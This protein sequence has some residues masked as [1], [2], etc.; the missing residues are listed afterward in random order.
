MLPAHAAPERASERMLCL[1]PLAANES[2]LGSA[3]DPSPPA[4]EPIGGRRWETKG[5]GCA[6]QRVDSFIFPSC[7]REA[8][9][10]SPLLICEEEGEGAGGPCTC[11]VEGLAVS[12]PGRE[13]P[14]GALPAPRFVRRFA[15]FCWDECQ[16]LERAGRERR[17]F[18]QIKSPL[19]P[20]KNGGQGR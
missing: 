3:L 11:P 12:P 2:I 5:G 9:P 8:S 14:L 19:P 16:R 10:S 7:E 1:S 13:A 6:E 18:K 20:P 17:R 4:V 15:P